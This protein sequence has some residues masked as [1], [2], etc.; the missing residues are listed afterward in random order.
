V[1]IPVTFVGF[2]VWRAIRG[3]DRRHDAEGEGRVRLEG[4]DEALRGQ[5]SQSGGATDTPGQ[6][7]HEVHSNEIWA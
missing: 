4:D 2:L 7:N 3:R 1:I 5:Q 6:G